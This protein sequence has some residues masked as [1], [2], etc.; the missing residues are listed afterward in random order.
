MITFRKAGIRLSQDY[1]PVDI[2]LQTSFLTKKESEDATYLSDLMMLA[3]GDIIHSRGDFKL[4]AGLLN[5]GQAL[6]H[7]IMS[8]KGRHPRDRTLGI[9]WDKYLGQ[10]Y[11]SKDLVIAELSTEIEEELYRDYRTAQVTYVNVSFLDVN[12]I[13]IETGVIPI[14]S[15]EEMI[16]SIEAQDR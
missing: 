1:N 13:S 5:Y 16:L 3:E 14:D 11:M 8:T 12:A 4:A 2:D 7:R 10:S 9:A 6:T 15:N